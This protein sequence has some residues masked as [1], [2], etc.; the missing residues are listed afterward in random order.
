M[1]EV[2]AFTVVNTGGIAL[3]HTSV[4]WR[5]ALLN[6]NTRTSTLLRGKSLKL[7]DLYNVTKREATSVKLSR[8]T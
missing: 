2:P 3:A 1:I 4:P 8:M 5:V 7:L 6:L